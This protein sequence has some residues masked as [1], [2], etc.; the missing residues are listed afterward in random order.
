MRT[1]CFLLFLGL[2]L[3][4]K[5]AVAQYFPPL[6]GSTWETTSVAGWCADSVPELYDYLEATG[7][8]AFIVL[9]GGRI[10]LEWY[11]SGHTSADAL[12]WFSAAKSYIAFLT[13]MA[14]EQGDLSIEDSTSHHLGTGW[15]S[16]TPQQEG[17][18]RI[19]HQLMM[20]SGLDE[21]T[22]NNDF[23]C[24]L[25]SCLTYKADTATRWAYHNA[26]YSLMADVLEAATG[27]TLNA[28]S[29]QFVENRTGMNG[30]WVS[31][32]YNNI[33]Y[34]NARTMARFGLLI[35][36]KGIWNGD[37][38][39]RDTAYFN[40]MLRP[41]GAPNQSYGYLWWLNGYASYMAPGGQTVFNGMLLPSA[42]PS[43][44]NALGKNGQIVSIVPEQELIM[45]RMGDAPNDAEVPI[46]LVDS[47]WQRLNSLTCPQDPVAR[48]ASS[49][50][51]PFHLYPNPATNQLRLQLQTHSGPLHYQVMNANGE[52]VRQGA[53]QGNT[54]S[55]A[56][57]PA[58]LYALRIAGTHWQGQR[59]FVKQ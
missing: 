56:D 33:F 29:N 50:S 26:P 22:T 40:T 31:S 37:T 59:T 20:A 45:I 28:I 38:L 52:C 54:L 30:L 32:G 44:I 2:F 14:Q 58:G 48:L 35:A 23:L 39:L 55:V 25:P 18:I 8:K 47:L 4:P 49:S 41:S 3:V 42:P 15:T 53:L 13:G 10:A 51:L 1:L 57:L 16:C 21:G 27:K 9:K 7:A 36:N 43:T 5:P 19:R 11:A 17:R 24:T 46:Q 34:S 12:P 6:T